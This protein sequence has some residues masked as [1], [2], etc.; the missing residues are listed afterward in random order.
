MASIQDH[1]PAIVA[2]G[3]APATWSRSDTM[4]VLGIYG[5]AVS[6]GTLF[7]PI[8][9]GLAGFW[10]MLIL[11]LLAFPMTF[12]TYR[13]LAKFIEMGS[14]TEGKDGNIIDTTEQHLGHKWGKIL[15]LMY[16]ATVFPSMTIY[17]I[18]LTN[19]IID[20]AHT[21]L[22]FQ[23]PS[24]YLVATLATLALTTLVRF[25]TTFI[26]KVMGTI[27]F[28]FIIALIVFGFM[29]I[30]HWN[31]SFMATA[32]NHDGVRGIISTTWSSIPMVVFAFSFTAITSSFVVAQKRKYGAEASWKVYQVMFVAV[33]LITTTVIFFSWS[34]IF[35][36]SPADLVAAKTSNL[37]ILSFLARQ[38]DNPA[39][40]YASQAIVFTA[41]IKSF[42]A[43]YLAT[44]ESARGFAR[45][46]LGMPER[47]LHT[48]RFTFVVASFVFVV[49]TA[50]A[51]LNLD[52]LK[53][54]KI[55][56][57]PVS[58]F[59]VYFLPQYAFRKVPA[60]QKYRGGFVNAF[61]S[62]IG[63]IC[64]VGSIASLVEVVSKF[65]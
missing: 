46:W 21:Q 64:L 11:C 2:S 52:I 57:V 35:A 56:L 50:A 41:T 5:N 55:F 38:F 60:L 20:F 26:V 6:G 33:A 15:T 10:P 36:L 51:I 61:I 37:T 45:T 25:G 54:I 18:A 16:F 43:H 13:T 40:A 39:M 48:N 29:A 42:L 44:E 34:C 1:G 14:N 58:L 8:D 24:R 9:L 59:V 31:T 49:C 27:V 63:L 22:G 19:T 23:P 28:P 65:H 7:W 53:L 3:T 47:L 32:T 4:W 62:V 12:L 30:P 17:T